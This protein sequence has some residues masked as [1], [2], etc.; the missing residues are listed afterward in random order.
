MHIS[1]MPRSG[2][3]ELL[4][5]TSKADPNH[6]PP[7]AAL[8]KEAL[9]PRETTLAKGTQLLMRKPPL[10]LWTMVFPKISEGEPVLHP[11]L[12]SSELATIVA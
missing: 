12:T 11:E 7:I 8:T 6:H 4:V 9:R 3:L 1:C 5:S 10:Q 2:E